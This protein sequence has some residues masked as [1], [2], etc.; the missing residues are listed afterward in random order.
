MLLNNY[1]FVKQKKSTNRRLGNGQK[2]DVACTT[3]EA[4]YFPKIAHPKATYRQSDLSVDYFL[5]SD[6]M[7]FI[8]L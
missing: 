6:S 2:K 4:D 5:K 8:H 1:I 3:M 7:L